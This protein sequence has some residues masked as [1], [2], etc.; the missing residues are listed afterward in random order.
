LVVVALVEETV[1]ARRVTGPELF[2]VLG[3]QKYDCWA[4]LK[5]L[6]LT[7]TF[8]IGDRDCSNI[9]FQI[10][11]RSNNRW[12]AL[13]GIMPRGQVFVALGGTCLNKSHRVQMRGNSKKD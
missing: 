4:S 5:D 12:K 8:S 13:S 1:V 6:K 7:P 10:R 3:F 9:Y 11:A 2:L